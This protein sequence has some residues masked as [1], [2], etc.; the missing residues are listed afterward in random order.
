MA[1]N[2][3]AA[4]GDK[5]PA[6][7]VGHHQQRQ[8]LTRL[9]AHNRL[10]SAILFAGTP[11][12]GKRLVAEELAR[13][14]L[15]CTARAP[16]G[17]CG[18]C[19]H[20]RLVASGNCPDYLQ[21][22]CLNRE[23]FDLDRLRELLHT[24]NM[25]PF[26]GGS[27]IIVLDNAD[28][29]SVQ[30][31]NLLLKSLE[32]P[33]PGNHFVLVCANPGMLPPTLLS[34]CQIWFFDRLT[35]AEIQQVLSAQGQESATMADLIALSDGS[36]ATLAS[37]REQRES[38]HAWRED[39]REI[40]EGDFVR[41]S[42]LA[43]ELSKQKENLRTSL[44]IL[45]I[46][47]REELRNAANHDCS[48]R[49]SSCMLDLLVAERLIFERNLGAQYVLQMILYKLS[50]HRAFTRSLGGATLLDQIIV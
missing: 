40:A 10:P 37:L 49:W 43:T 14:V 1:A 26:L 42:K 3:P 11:G 9:T 23:E 41:A 4:T 46:I 20:C 32:E 30:A 6:S 21:S 36:L 8:M 44:Q 33:R 45:R 5:S 15:C 24:L 7:L 50:D 35:P 18:T 27:R 39:L 38:W 28:H 29:L 12:I 16:Y 22:D 48:F 17:G 25:R 2:T 13:T 19:T 31:A 34:R 47:A